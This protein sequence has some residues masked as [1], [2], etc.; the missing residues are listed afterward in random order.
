MEQNLSSEA[1]SHSASWQISK[2]LWNLYVHIHGLT[3][4]CLQNISSIS[5]LVFTVL[6]RLI[7]KVSTVSL[8]KKKS[9]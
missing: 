9:S 7:Q 8:Q 4:F 6:I 2:P 1:D 5:E 3:L